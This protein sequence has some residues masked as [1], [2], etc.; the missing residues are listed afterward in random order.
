MWSFPTPTLSTCSLH[1]TSYYYWAA[2]SSQTHAI[3]SRIF[4]SISPLPRMLLAS[5]KTLIPLANSFHPLRFSLG[6]L[7]HKASP[8]PSRCLLH[9]QGWISSFALPRRLQR[10]FKLTYVRSPLLLRKLYEG[11]IHHCSCSLNLAKSGRSKNVFWAD[12]HLFLLRQTKVLKMSS[13]STFQVYRSTVLIKEPQTLHD[14]DKQQLAYS[15][16]CSP[17][18][19]E[20]VLPLCP[21]SWSASLPMRTVISKISCLINATS[22]EPIAPKS[23]V[24]WMQSRKRRKCQSLSRVWLFCDPTDGNPPGSSVPGILQASLLEWVV[25]PFS[26]GSSR[27]W[28]RT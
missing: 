16:S 24:L 13:L 11:I 18:F 15:L 6:F 20:P 27:P 8:S 25:I 2:Q 17:G 1:F 26:R 10:A 12:T 23:Y 14:W 5:P 28:D 9:G 21:A 4:G 19:L 7:I 22:G 3:S